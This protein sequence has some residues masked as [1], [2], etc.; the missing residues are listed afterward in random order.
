MRQD[1][2]R[3]RGAAGIQGLAAF[4]D[5]L[6]DPF[7]ID[8]KRGA[9]SKLL[10]LVK[11]SIVLHYRSFKIAQQR[12]CHADLLGKLFIG[13]D[14]VDAEAQDLCVAGF[15]FGDIS[16]IRLKFGRSTTSEGQ[17]VD[18]QH[19]IFLTLKITELIGLAIGG[20]QGKVG[21][22]LANF[23]ICVRRRRRGF[24][25]SLGSRSRSRRR[26]RCLRGGDQRSRHQQ[27]K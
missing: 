26:S 6:D 19:H 21:R 20:P 7:L 27:E 3:V 16:L 2:A 22:R 9:V 23:Q 14:A 18:G 8:H 1:V 17:D 11:D 10:I 12:K 15:E 4:I 25:R 13:G 5:A 24:G